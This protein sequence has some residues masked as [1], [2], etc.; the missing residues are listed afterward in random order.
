[1]KKTTMTVDELGFKDGMFRYKIKLIRN[2][3][4]YTF[5][6]SQGYAITEKPKLKDVLYCLAMDSLAYTN[7]KNWQDFMDS[8]GYSD[9]KEAQK[10]YNAC[11]KTNLALERLGFTMNDIINLSELK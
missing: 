2:K 11:R 8:F 3:K 10:I 7:H 5:P 4:Q 9:W 1:M 6:F